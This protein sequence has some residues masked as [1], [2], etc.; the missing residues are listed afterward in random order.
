MPPNEA[1]PP[2][3]GSQQLATQKVAGKRDATVHPPPAGPHPD[4][5]HATIIL[6]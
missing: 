2:T 3:P 1:K 5:L 4:W 6:L